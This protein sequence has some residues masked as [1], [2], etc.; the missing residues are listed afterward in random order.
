M[1]AVGGL[2]IDKYEASV[3]DSPN[4]G[5]Q[6]G[7]AS[8][9]Y[10][11]NDNGQN[12]LDI[13]ARSVAGVTPS[14]YITWFQAQ[15]ACQNVGKRLATNAEWQQAVSGT[16]DPGPDN[17]MTDCNT[18]NGAAVTTGSRSS[19]MSAAGAFDMVGNLQEWVA[20]WVPASTACPNWGVFS[21]DSMCLSG[22]STTAIGPGALMRGGSFDIGTGAGP[23]SVIGNLPSIFISDTY[24]FRCAR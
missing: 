21:N 1:I 24:G 6:Y 7:A 2:C 22:A 9:D 14:A 12:C 13:Y 16:P 10:P 3:W 18:A 19:C 15:Q 8:D 17:G 4:G 11:C 20:D 5:T 23:L